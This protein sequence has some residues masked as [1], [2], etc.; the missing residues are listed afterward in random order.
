VNEERGKCQLGVETADATGQRLADPSRVTVAL[1]FAAVAELGTGLENYALSLTEIVA[2]TDTEA[3]RS[4]VGT[5]KT[6][7]LN[8]NDTI[9]G[10]TGKQVV[11]RDTF[12]PVADLVESAL[13]AGFEQRRFNAMKR[14]VKEADP[15]ITDTAQYLS[16]ASMVL[17]IPELLTLR[18][19][20]D[21]SIISLNNA[22]NADEYEELVG[23]AREAE[24]AYTDALDADFSSTFKAMGEAHTALKQALEDPD[25]EFDHLKEQIEL[26]VTQAEAVQAAVKADKDKED[27]ETK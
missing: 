25:R 4:S 5:A 6:A 8:L 3:L 1:P 17:L 7:I 11:E 19:K 14:V 24:E 10:A 23:R 20:Y 12:S 26:F 22:T 21:N 15:I 13:I 9:D 2:T 18:R 16:R 27:E